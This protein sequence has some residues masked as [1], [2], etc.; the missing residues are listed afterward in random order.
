MANF[1]TLRELAEQVGDDEPILSRPLGEGQLANVTET[2]R[3]LSAA[4]RRI[5]AAQ[6]ALEACRVPFDHSPF[7]KLSECLD[8]AWLALQPAMLAHIDA[9]DAQKPQ[10]GTTK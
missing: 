1:S 7:R 5:D 3:L 8:E 9:L 10:K 6:G 4:G 2:M